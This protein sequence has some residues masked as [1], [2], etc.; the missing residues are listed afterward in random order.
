MLA[1]G[2]SK[3]ESAESSD[4]E[5]PPRTKTC[6]AFCKRFGECV[7]KLCEPKWTAGIRL[8]AG[9]LAEDC[10]AGCTDEVLRQEVS[11]E[12]WRCYYSQSCHA[13]FDQDVC[14]A[15]ASYRCE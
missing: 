15:D 9:K 8:F 5:T 11:D 3:S 7:T 4:V 10:E 6:K 13:V 12:M 1:G 14:K 2:C